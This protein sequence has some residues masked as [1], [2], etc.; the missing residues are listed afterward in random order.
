VWKPGAWLG[1]IANGSGSGTKAA[2]PFDFALMGYAV[3][4]IGD[5][6]GDGRD[7]PLFSAP[8]LGEGPGSVYVGNSFV[9]EDPYGSLG[10]SLSSI[11]DLNGDG[12]PE[13]LISTFDGAHVV[14]GRSDGATVLIDDAGDIA[15]GFRIIGAGRT[16]SATGDMNDDGLEEILANNFVIWGK[17][18]NATVDVAD[19]A[20]GIGGFAVP[21]A[22]HLA[23][24]GTDLNG[25]GVIDLIAATADATYVV[26]GKADTAPVDLDAV[27]DG[28][29]GFKVFGEGGAPIATG[30][31]N[32]DGL[33]E[34]LFGEPSNADGSLSGGA[35]FVVFSSAAWLHGG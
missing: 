19:V 6:D 4:A 10:A 5:L 28:I 11:G 9:V 18:D 35:A 20:A 21:G 13:V 15:D 17:G 8:T 31:M 3:G 27:G 2:G 33:P 25:D 16:I 1:G 22:W 7:E 26:W 32:G 34:L 23:S 29:G 30:D 12:R 14:W 24:L